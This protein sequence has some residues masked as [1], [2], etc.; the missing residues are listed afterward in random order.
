MKIL[1]EKKQDKIMK[2]LADLQVTLLKANQAQLEC[3]NMSQGL[4]GLNDLS[5]G[6]TDIAKTVGGED[7][8]G[9]YLTEVVKYTGIGNV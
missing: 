7:G 8:F 3:T 1:T 2:K 9:I 5:D 4:Y 6:I